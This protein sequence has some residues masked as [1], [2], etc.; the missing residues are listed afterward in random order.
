VHKKIVSGFLLAIMLLNLVAII[1]AD[2][3]KESQTQ[4]TQN[5][6]KCSN[7]SSQITNYE[8]SASNK[9]ENTSTPQLNEKTILA[10]SEGDLQQKNQELN[11]TN[12]ADSITRSYDQGYLSQQILPDLSSTVN[13]ETTDNYQMPSNSTQPQTIDDSQNNLLSYP[14]SE[15]NTSIPSSQEIP[16]GTQIDPLA[17]GSLGVY[18][19]N[20]GTGGAYVQGVHVVLYDSG[21]HPLNNNQTTNSAGY[22]YWASLTTGTYNIE[23]Y[24]KSPVGLGYEEFWGGDTVTV[25]GTYTL[26]RHTQYITGITVNG[27][28]PGSDIEVN[29]GDNVQFVITVQNDENTAKSTKVT[30]IMDHSK[31]APWD[32][33]QDSTVVSI[34]SHGSNNFVINFNANDYGSYWAY[35]S[36]NALYSQYFYT[37]Q[38]NWFVGCFVKPPDLAWNNIWT[39]PSAPVA[40][41]L[42]S[43]YCQLTNQGAGSTPVSFT[44]YFY[45]D[46]NY[47]SYGTNN[48]LA[49]GSTYN[50]VINNY[51]SPGYH[52][53]TASAD[54][55]GNVPESNKGNNLYTTSPIWFKSPD[56]T[57]SNIRWQDSYGNLNGAITSGQPITIYFTIKNSGDADAIGQFSTYVTTSE[58]NNLLTVTQNGLAAGNSI[59]YSF[60]NVIFSNVGTGTI[61]ATVDYQKNIAEANTLTGSGTGTGETNNVLTANINVQQAAWTFITYFSCGSV[62]TGSDLSSAINSNVNHIKNVGSSP[63]LSLVTLA[64]KSGN[65][66]TF[67]CFYNSTNTV[68]IPLNQISGSWQNELDMG[69]RQ[70]LETFVEYTMN[71][72]KADHYA[73]ILY[74][75]GGDLQGAVRDEGYPTYPDILSVPDMATAL[76]DIS[77]NTK[78]TK[79]DVFG[80]DACLMATTEV[81]YQIRNHTSIFVASEKDSYSNGRD[82]SWNYG[83]FLSLLKNNPSTTASALATSIISSTLTLYQQRTTDSFTLSAID[84]TKMD[85]LA[86]S[87]K[88]LADILDQNWRTDRPLILNA[89]SE[90]EQYDDP[91]MVDLYHFT[92]RIYSD[93]PDSSIRQACSNVQVALTNAVIYEQHYTGTTDPIPANHA[94][95]LTIW[96]PNTP[97]DYNNYINYYYGLDF[98]H[99][100]WADPTN[101]IPASFI[102]KCIFNSSSAPLV[103]I[104][105]PG[106]SQ[107]WS[108]TQTISWAGFSQDYAS[109]SY[110]VYISTNGGST[111]NFLTNS[112]YEESPSFATHT[113]NLDTTQFGD[114]TNCIVKI[115]Y[116][117]GIY[118]GTVLS[119]T[120]SID[121][122]P[123]SCSIV[124]FAGNPRFTIV[125]IDATSGVSSS[126]YKIDGG[127]YQQYSSA[128]TIPAGTTHT[129]TA[130]STDN[131]NNNSPETSL[132]IYSLTMSTNYGTI[133]PPSGWY[134]QGYSVTITATPPQ[135]DPGNNYIWQGWTGSG[136]GSYIGS[137]NPVQITVNSPITQ[138]ATWGIVQVTFDFGVGSS[139]PSQTVTAGGST[140]YPVTV[141]L[142]SGSTQSVSLSCSPSITSVSYTFAPVSNNPTFTSTLTVQTGADT[143]AGTY[144]LTITGTGGAL[145]HTTTVQL[146]IQ[147]ISPPTTTITFATGGLSSDTGSAIILIIGSTSYTYAQLPV[148]FVWDVGS[149]HAVTAS[150]VLS[151][152]TGKE[153]QFLS[154]TNGNGLSGSSGTFTVP[155]SPTTVTAN[156]QAFYILTT[157]KVGSGILSRNPDQTW[158]AFGT[159]VTLTANPISGWS[160]TSWSGDLSG[161]TSPTQITMDGPKTVTATFT[162]VWFSLIT[163]VVGS[164]SVSRSPN[165][166]IFPPGTVVTLTANP[167]SGWV[168]SGWSGDLTGTANPAQITTGNA[169][170]TVTA[171]FTQIPGSIVPVVPTDGMIIT[172]NTVFVPG[173]YNLP[174]G[175]TIS[176]SNI[177]LDGNGATLVG[178]GT[179]YVT[180]IKDSGTV[181]GITVKN[182]NVEYYWD[183]MIIY[184]PYSQILNNVV[185][186]CGHVCIGAYTSNLKISN[187]IVAGYN[188]SPMHAQ[189]RGIDLD[190]NNC[191]ISNN[192]ATNC[193][194]K[195]FFIFNSQ[196]F[197]VTNNTSTNHGSYGYE[198]GTASYGSFTNNIGS[199]NG[200]D[201]VYASGGGVNNIIFSNNTLSNNGR[202]GIILDSGPTDNMISKNVFNSN[203]YGVFFQSAATTANTAMQNEISNNLV[204]GLISTGSGN[205]IYHNNFRNNPT[206]ASQ[207]SGVDNWYSSSL[208]EGNYWSDYTGTDNNNDGKGETPYAV[209]S[210]VFDNYPLMSPCITNEVY[211]IYLLLSTDPI[212]TYPRGQQVTFIVTVLNQQNPKLETT[213]TLTITGPGGYSFYDFQ[214]INVSTNSAGEYSFSWIVPNVK[215]TYIVETSLAPAQLTA[216]DAK[217]LEVGESA[218][219]SAVSKTPRF[220]FSSNMLNEAFA[221]LILVWSQGISGIS[222][223]AL[224]NYRSKKIGLVSCALRKPWRLQS[225]FQSTF[226]SHR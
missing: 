18:V 96:F 148:S 198:F 39:S 139:V 163:N 218:S 83:T 187:N 90:T 185:T 177:V 129:I 1:S 214:P 199:F 43:V 119:G 124:H 195:G 121:N 183:G 17:T 22:A 72:F 25:P 52:T 65:G 55:Y 220:S 67:A 225:Q 221:L 171:T 81:A 128:V 46:G 217:W 88:N 158:Y 44:N 211:S 66:D 143:P 162:E 45:I 80:L 10:P 98:V 84:L 105:R 108:G 103:D 166:P 59:E 11:S 3:M 176:A 110:N 38:Y 99:E 71:R 120:F 113:I 60:S 175:I 2:Q 136:T 151:A 74:D 36:V 58:A 70:T 145:V 56:L 126:Y 63:Q 31:T 200:K 161:S 30:L 123:P 157:N 213:L 141:T 111:W 117:D 114:S 68:N 102:N 78:V 51:F 47:N 147:P 100:D 20:Q 26:T 219:E 180:G 12:L 152:G 142:L 34:P 69:V 82:G 49:A 28:A 168:F 125:A 206:Q 54:Y 174:N 6:L 201:G 137:S 5:S 37:D 169:P 212:S 181:S 172:Q 4:N 91:W 93:I 222:V 32:S 29:P 144:T 196:N 62:I 127:A 150:S 50:W 97:A 92:E 95:G 184:A 156:W 104:M 116:N 140:T 216:Y 159:V 107:A 197:V 85:N 8:L 208:L 24:Y 15:N 173:I 194:Y 86:I 154:W 101:G 64:D 186:Y 14:E 118:S 27:Q 134:D 189:Q 205:L 202:A 226:Q 164:G 203:A 33:S 223:I 165:Q 167:A 224:L 215:G 89:R 210:N 76:Q 146:I 155:S 207:Q 135:N 204:T 106:S 41:Q 160:F 94:H 209:G 115:S 188:V 109:V 132:T 131:T 79:I 193:L 48:G 130:Y 35:L 13:N 133:D 190:G 179:Q 61:T 153:Y 178:V 112:V 53:I 182:C 170:K 122:T 138:T 21:Y 23:A 7:A 192:T 9:I 87:I 57:V 40:G 191:V 42:T 16:S 73:L 75:H 149:Q 77:T 19:K